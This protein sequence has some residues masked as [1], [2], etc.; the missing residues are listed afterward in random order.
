M[1]T[2]LIATTILV[3]ALALPAAL[4][5]QETDPAAVVTAMLEAFHARDVDAFLALYADDAAVKITPPPPGVSGEFVVYTGQEELRAWVEGL[6]AVN[7]H[8]EFEILQVEGDTVIGSSWYWDDQIRALGI[9]SV[10]AAEEYTIQQGK[11]TYLTYTL[12][13]ESMA[14]LYAA[15]AAL[16]QTGGPSPTG[17]L[18]LWLGIG[19]VL[20]LALGL[21]AGLRRTSG[22]A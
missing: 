20:L 14:E 19:G 3:L 16:P 4:Y 17:T 12:S 21:G 11:I 18:P 5:A 10:E 8:M 9:E 1:K 7:G 6:I 13:E 2:R 15:M 22:G